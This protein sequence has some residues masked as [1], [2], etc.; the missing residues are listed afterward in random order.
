MRSAHRLRRVG[1]AERPRTPA[2]PPTSSS[3]EAE[4]L[5][6]MAVDHPPPA[7]GPP[8]VVADG[9]AGPPLRWE[10]ASPSPARRPPPRLPCLAPE[11]R[12]ARPGAPWRPSSCAGS[13]PPSRCAFRSARH[14][15]AADQNRSLAAALAGPIPR[16]RA[17]QGLRSL[18][19]A[20][21]E[22]LREL[23]ISW[24]VVRIEIPKAA[25][26]FSRIGD[27]CGILQGR[28]APSRRSWT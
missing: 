12:S 18:R 4:E 8:P 27:A 9:T 23:F 16:S 1:A 21:L 5:R 17:G 25:E 7:G 22:L 14:Q 26:V 19:R 15:R 24:Y 20:H 10:A 13:P 28:I 11:S 6:L 3:P 2:S